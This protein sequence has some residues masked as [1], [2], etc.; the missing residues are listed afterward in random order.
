M[1][2][3]GC[4]LAVQVSDGGCTL[5]VQVSD[6]GCTLAVQVSEGGCTLAVQV[7]EGGCIP[8]AVLQQLGIL[9][10]RGV[11]HSWPHVQ[12]LVMLEVLGVCHSWLHVQQLLAVNRAVLHAIVVGHALT[13][14]HCHSSLSLIRSLIPPLS[15]PH[16][17][18]TTALTQPSSLFPLILHGNHSQHPPRHPGH[19]PLASHLGVCPPCCCHRD[20]ACRMYNPWSFSIAFFLCELPYSFVQVGLGVGVLGFMFWVLSFGCWGF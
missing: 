9:E 4:T 18:P 5:A 7:S 14:T 3:G 16:P 15:Y 19:S 6:G 8:Q 17:Q 20:S 11:C 10:I 13:L 1:S 2:D 12:Q